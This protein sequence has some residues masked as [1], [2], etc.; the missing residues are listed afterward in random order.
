[1]NGGAGS[2]HHSSS[3]STTK[4]E[5]DAYN[6]GLYTDSSEGHVDHDPLPPTP[7]IPGIRIRD[8]NGNTSVDTKALKTYADNLDTLCDMVGTARDKVF[9][10]RALA[11]GA[12]KEAEDLK[13]T[14]S[15]PKD[16]LQQHYVDAMH[17]LREALKKVAQ[18]IR[19]LADKYATIEELNKNAGQE[20]RDLITE[21]QSDV[22]KLQKD[23][24]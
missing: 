2:N 21:A 3:S 19:D 12:F 22:Q 11:P 15:D 9:H 23:P 4:T 24:L 20:L 17:Q 8:G 1:M 14:I 18:Q 16:G 6:G 13:K 7:V 10:L 5:P